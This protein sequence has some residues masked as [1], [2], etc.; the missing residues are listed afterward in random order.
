MEEAA[1]RAARRLLARLELT[2]TPA[3]E[4]S[5]ATRDEAQRL[6]LALHLAHLREKSESGKP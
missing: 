3:D 5:E 1:G 6:L 2:A 4:K